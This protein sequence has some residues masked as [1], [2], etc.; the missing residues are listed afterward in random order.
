[1]YVFV[2]LFDFCF[3]I[4]TELHYFIPLRTEGIMYLKVFLCLL[5]IFPTI[6]A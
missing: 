2:I 3:A 1:M 6:L 5:L 4:E